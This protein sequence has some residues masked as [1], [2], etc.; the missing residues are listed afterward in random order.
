MIRVH[1]GPF[2]ATGFSLGHWTHPDGTTGCTVL[3]ADRLSPGAVEVRGGSP[4]TRETDLL[5]PGR[6]VQAADA[7][8][9]TGGSAFGLAAAD[10]VVR[11]LAERGR[12][13]PTGTVNVPIVPGAV[14]FDL[15]GSEP[16]WPNADAGY[17]AAQSANETWSSGRVGGGTG[18]SSSKVLGR[19][20]A[21]PTGLG[22]AQVA[23]P[24]GTVSAVI[25]NNAFGDVLN[26]RDG[27]VLT[28]PGG[29]GTPTEALILE[30]TDRTPESPNTVLGAV[31]VDRP[32]HHDALTRLSMAGQSGLAR[33]V[34]PAHSPADG[35]TIFA[36]AP[37]WGDCSMPELMQL[38]T[39][40]QIACARATVNSV[41]LG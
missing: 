13:Y 16:V 5:G 39:A 17:A 15:A 37:E 35:D 34:R 7:L 18:A 4:G 19:E 29:Q 25:V 11:W 26:D 1:D 6:S 9:L 8:L 30:E 10:G 40:A 24:A 3:I 14:I 22:V 36:L 38:V 31:V 23:S 12:G 27:R 21:I 41:I 2:S 32:L 20:Q 33:V 28:T